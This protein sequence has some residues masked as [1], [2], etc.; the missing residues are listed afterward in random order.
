[1]E[2]SNPLIVLDPG[3]WPEFYASVPSA[4]VCT[5]EISK[6][7]EALFSSDLSAE[8]TT[9]AFPVL[10]HRHHGASRDQRGADGDDQ[11]GSPRPSSHPEAP[12]PRQEVG[13]HTRLGEQQHLNADD[14]VGR[15]P[16]NQDWANTGEEVLRHSA[17]VTSVGNVECVFGS[18]NTIYRER[19][20]SKS[21]FALCR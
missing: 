6:Q 2:L 4:S 18:R 19:G 1:M 11:E 13:T 12:P 20:S 15:F 14:D 9:D 7:F 16:H 8:C 5:K 17:G 21:G 10:L 3:Y